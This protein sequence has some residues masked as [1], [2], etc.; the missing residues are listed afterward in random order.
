[1]TS[2]AQHPPVRVWDLPTRAFHWLLALAVIG[3]VVTA[4]VGGNAMLWHMRL[5]LVVRTLLSLPHRLGSGRRAL[6]ALCQLHLR[7]RHGAA[8]PAWRPPAR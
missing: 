4:K 3:L 8:L 1:M 7:T 5:G 6:V 2:D